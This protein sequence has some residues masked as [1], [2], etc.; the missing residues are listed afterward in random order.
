MHALVWPPACLSLPALARPGRVWPGQPS[1][2]PG[3]AWPGHVPSATTGCERAGGGYLGDAAE[4]RMGVGD[5]A[6]QARLRGTMRRLYQRERDTHASR[7]CPGQVR[8]DKFVRHV[9]LSRV[10]SASML[11]YRRPNMGGGCQVGGWGGWGVPYPPPPPP[12]KLNT[13]PT[14]LSA[15]NTSPAHMCGSHEWSMNPNVISTTSTLIFE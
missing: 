4:R 8:P 15:Q 10:E 3:P 13:P 5:H 2:D 11:I 6:P 1:P 14:I 9:C 7:T 12:P